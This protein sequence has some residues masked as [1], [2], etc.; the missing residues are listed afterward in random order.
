MQIKLTN[1]IKKRILI[2]FYLKCFRNSSTRNYLFSRS[3]DVVFVYKM[4]SKKKFKKM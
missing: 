4:K 3:K 1:K 2:W